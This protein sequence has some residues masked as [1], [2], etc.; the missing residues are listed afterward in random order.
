[1]SLRP[2][3]WPWRAGCGTG[4]S[5]ATRTWERRSGVGATVALKAGAGWEGSWAR[6]GPAGKRG[7][8]RKAAGDGLS[9]I[10]EALPGRPRVREGRARVAPSSPQGWLSAGRW[11]PVA[12]RGGRQREGAMSSLRRVGV[13]VERGGWRHGFGR[14]QGHGVRV[15]KPVIRGSL[16]ITGPQP[17]L[18]G[19]RIH[20]PVSLRVQADAATSFL[21][22][23]R[24]GNLDKALDH[25]RNGVDINT[26][27]QVSEMAGLSSLRCSSCPVPLAQ[28]FETASI[29]LFPAASKIPKGSRQRQALTSTSHRG[30]RPVPRSLLSEVAA[31][32]CCCR[33]TRG[34]W[35]RAGGRA[36]EGSCVSGDSESAFHQ[37]LCGSSAGLGGNQ[38]SLGSV[39]TRA[40][41]RAR[42]AGCHGRDASGRPGPLLTLKQG[43]VSTGGW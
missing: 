41:L 25:L 18:A 39:P 24:S 30:C 33:R 28:S 38:A 1:M 20:A 3:P 5:G 19:A 40:G 17:R 42:R 16:G 2:R 15:R 35:M 6:A 32:P 34:L 10:P 7:G 36:F 27:N 4:R 8:P 11:S 26:C 37:A 9:S 23:A 43:S 14:R 29:N 22:A 12:G 13:G 31:G 21:R